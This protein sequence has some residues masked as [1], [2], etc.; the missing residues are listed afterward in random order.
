MELKQGLMSTRHSKI[1]LA[2]NMQTD[3]NAAQHLARLLDG[4]AKASSADP[5][6]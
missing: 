2:V 1:S 6:A 4:D 3:Q 5:R